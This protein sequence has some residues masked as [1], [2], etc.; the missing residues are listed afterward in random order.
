M[1]IR[2]A[3]EKSFGSSVINKSIVYYDVPILIQLRGDV[4][5]SYTIANEKLGLEKA[6]FSDLD[7]TDFSREDYIKTAKDMF[8]D[9]NMATRAVDVSGDEFYAEYI[10]KAVVGGIITPQISEN[11]TT[12]FNGDGT[13]S[14]AEVLDGINA[15]DM[16]CNSN[17]C[18]K[19]SLDNIS[20]VDDYFNE[21][22]NLC[23]WG[24]SSPFFNLYTRAELLNP[25]TRIE[26]GYI[27]VMCS[28]VFDSIF[29]GSKDMG[30]SFDW[31][32]PMSVISKFDDW[33]SYNISLVS[34]DGVPKYDIHEYKGTR[35]MCNYIDDIHSGRS[36]IPLPMIMSLLE[37]GVNNL[38]Y[39]ED[40]RLNPL[41]QVSRGEI[42]YLLT[43]I[44]EYKEDNYD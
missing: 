43:K 15:I 21:G 40:S 35:T 42:C 28:G 18:R 4:S 22:Y 9:V 25:I 29:K 41:K 27:V 32:K 8:P 6:S 14:I 33:N 16:G 3:A 11:G 30:I 36:A 20:N 26:L 34:K 24:Y 39:F 38:F 12:L 13:V 7:S 1:F 44:A 37:L 17:V 2:H 19:T 31:L 10:P 5:S 23:C